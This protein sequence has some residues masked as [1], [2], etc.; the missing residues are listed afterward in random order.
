MERK[1]LDKQIIGSKI[2][3]ILTMYQRCV[4]RGDVA[5]QQRLVVVED[6]PNTLARGS[7]E[8]MP[9]DKHNGRID[10][11]KARSGIKPNGRA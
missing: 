7:V 9:I 11:I 5:E 3:A 8:S 2:L 4:R 10:D 1:Y 6:R